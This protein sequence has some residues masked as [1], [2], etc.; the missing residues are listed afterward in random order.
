MALIWSADAV[1][2]LLLHTRLIS[3]MD[4]LVERREMGAQQQ[5][6]LEDPQSSMKW[7]PLSKPKEERSPAPTRRKQML[8]NQH[9][10]GHPLMTTI[11]QS[12]YSF[13]QIVN[14]YVKLLY[15]QILVPLQFT[16][17]LTPPPPFNGSLTILP[18]QVMNLPTKQPK[19]SPLSPPTQSFLFLFSALYR[20]NWLIWLIDWFARIHLHTNALHKSTN[21]KRLP[22][23][24]NLEFNTYFDCS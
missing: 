10:P 17:P 8:W 19:K 6:L 2:L 11:F 14:H 22:V 4:P 21:T 23:T 7:L 5:F 1:S 24:I 18:F 13:G 12:P 9:N 16:I 20:L 3:P 15:H